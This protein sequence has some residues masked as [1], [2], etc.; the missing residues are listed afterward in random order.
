[1]YKLK[2][3]K[4]TDIHKIRNT[5][6]YKFYLKTFGDDFPEYLIDKRMF[7]AFKHEPIN[8]INVC[9]TIAKHIGHKSI[10]GLVLDSS[11]D[12]LDYDPC[13][14]NLNILN[15]YK[16]C[17]ENIANKLIISENGIMLNYDPENVE[18][19]LSFIDAKLSRGQMQKL[20]LRSYCRVIGWDAKCIEQ[21]YNLLNLNIG[22]KL[23]DAVVIK[24]RG[25]VL[26]MHKDLSVMDKFNNIS[27]RR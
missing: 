27:I 15:L 20:L 25:I 6:M 13:S 22:K 5:E 8:S 1:M 21:S 19:V 12:I 11:T 17:G 23:T 9:D 4:D 10:K 16:Y 14:I 18:K 24:S 26:I 7:R 3:P 2:F